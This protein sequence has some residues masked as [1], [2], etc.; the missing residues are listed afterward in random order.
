MIYTI[1]I[2]PDARPV[3]G[4]KNGESRFD[5]LKA[6]PDGKAIWAAVIPPLW[7]TYHGLWFALLMYGGVL[8][9]FFVL[10][11]SFTPAAITVLFLGGLPGLYLFLEGHQLRRVKLMSRGYKMLGVVDSHSENN[12][13]EKFLYYWEEPIPSP[14]APL[15]K[16]PNPGHDTPD[17]TLFPQNEA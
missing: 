12:A 8:L 1:H 15:K 14:P 2:G 6:V 5:S 9:L 11:I 13:L 3:P 16:R 7:L 10:A 17:F 4:D